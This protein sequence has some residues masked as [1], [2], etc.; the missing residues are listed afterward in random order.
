MKIVLAI[1]G[2]LII[3]AALSAVVCRYKITVA[4]YEVFFE[5]LSS[6]SRVVVISDLHCRKYGDDNS[7][8]ISL[9][10]KQK[11]DALFMVGDMVSR[12]ADDA[13]IQSFA[14]LVTSLREYLPVY[15]S[16]GNHENE[17]TTQKLAQLMQAVTRAGGIF[18]NN[19]YADVCL[20]E[21]QIRLVGILGGNEPWQNYYNDDAKL[22]ESY[23]PYGYLK[24][25]RDFDKPTVWLAHMPNMMIFFE[26]YKEYRMDL[27]LSGHVHGGLWDI[28][29][30]GGV[31]S[32]SEGFFPHYDKGEYRFD[33]TEFILSAGLAGYK[34]IPRIFNL[35]EICVID[36]LPK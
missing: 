10:L 32:P 21:N 18:L 8:L 26:P 4:S 22:P 15:Y 5:G 16:I 19:E 34:W 17:L 1:C 20:G 27:V 6:S 23:E 33:D 36:L 25:L 12:D 3:A 35:P 29:A 2:A 28:P 13:D 14:K 9:I 7:R 30:I 31:I 24:Y 11:P